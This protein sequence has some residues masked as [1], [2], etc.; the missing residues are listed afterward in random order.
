[1]DMWC[2]KPPLMEAVKQV[3]ASSSLIKPLSST[4]HFQRCCSRP[5]ALSGTHKDRWSGQ[6]LTYLWDWGAEHVKRAERRGGTCERR[7]H[8]C[9]T[10]CWQASLGRR[11]PAWVLFTATP[12]HEVSLPGLEHRQ[13]G[14]QWAHCSPDAPAWVTVDA[15]RALMA[16]LGSANTASFHQ[17]WAL[18]SGSRGA[19]FNSSFLF[20]WAC[21]S[22]LHYLYYLFGLWWL[23]YR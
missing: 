12:A 14:S 11:R 22:R 9:F 5:A 18:S 4:S 13:S 10:L 2:L 23:K 20:F 8:E 7:G 3:G 19:S 21:V 16:A 15:V 1:M 6:L 17:R